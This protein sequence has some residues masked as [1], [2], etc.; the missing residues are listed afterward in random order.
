MVSHDSAGQQRI[1]TAR[2]FMR[3]LQQMLGALGRRRSWAVSIRETEES[4]QLKGS[5]QRKQRYSKV[6]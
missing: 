5:R 6:G 3:N 2:D 1:V 4:T